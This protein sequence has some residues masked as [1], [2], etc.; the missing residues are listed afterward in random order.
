MIYLPEASKKCN[1]G[2]FL[3]LLATGSVIAS[4]GACIE[5]DLESLDILHEYFHV[6]MLLEDDMGVIRRTKETKFSVEVH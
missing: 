3:K 4:K 5:A 6:L 1:I 2:H